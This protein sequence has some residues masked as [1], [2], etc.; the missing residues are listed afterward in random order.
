MKKSTDS[1]SIM[2]RYVLFEQN[3][4]PI[5]LTMEDRNETADS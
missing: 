3:L 5:E 2:K 4:R 1:K